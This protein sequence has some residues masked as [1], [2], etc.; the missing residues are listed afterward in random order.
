MAFVGGNSAPCNGV[1]GS[2][3]L[4]L[5]APGPTTSSTTAVGIAGGLYGGGGS[6]GLS[7]QGSGTEAGGAGAKGLVIITEYIG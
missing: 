6:G 7:F 2:T 4:G 5:G 1:G 3:P